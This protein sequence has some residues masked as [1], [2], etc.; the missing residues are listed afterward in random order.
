MRGP[1]RERVAKLFFAPSENVT[2]E[3][4]VRGAFQRRSTERHQGHFGVKVMLR[5]QV[6]AATQLD[7][8]REL[9]LAVHHAI[10]WVEF[11]G[12]LKQNGNTRRDLCRFFVGGLSTGQ[13]PAVP[14]LCR[15]ERSA[16]N[17]M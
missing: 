4:P 10:R 12:S 5:V 16:R 9:L 7:I 1:D 8:R 11:L 3:Q 13:D 6:R 17:Q 2:L 14:R 15:E